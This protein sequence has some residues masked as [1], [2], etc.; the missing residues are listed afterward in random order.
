MDCVDS[1]LTI[2]AYLS[3]RSPF[4]TS[5][6]S[7]DNY[8]KVLAHHSH[9]DSP[10]SDHITVLL[11]YR[12]WAEY[13]EKDGRDVAFQFCRDNHLSYSV[14]EDISMLR[15]LFYENLVRAGLVVRAD[16]DCRCKDNGDNLSL[17]KCCLCAGDT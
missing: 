15:D 4:V 10:F 2:A 12:K 1:A 9:E 5:L 17:L 3:G 14:L 7:K 13:L 11:I 8:Y 6:H 16:L